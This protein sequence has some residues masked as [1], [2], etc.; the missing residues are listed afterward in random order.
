MSDRRELI[1]TLHQERVRVDEVESSEF[2]AL[3]RPQQKHPNRWR[4]VVSTQGVCL[5]SHRERHRCML[6]GSQVGT[7]LDCI[8]DELDGEARAIAATMFRIL[9]N[10]AQYRE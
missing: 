2:P 8:S 9:C 1:P 4:G 7:N 10:R 5:E 3:P 6:H